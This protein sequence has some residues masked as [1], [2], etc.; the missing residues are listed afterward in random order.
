[1][2]RIA[3]MRKQPKKNKEKHANGSHK[4]KERLHSTPEDPQLNQELEEQIEKIKTLPEDEFCKMFE[5]ML[6]CV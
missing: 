4:A 5:K 6:V 2:N 1:M 3:S